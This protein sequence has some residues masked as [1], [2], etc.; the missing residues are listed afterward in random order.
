MPK[1]PLPGAFAPKR[2]MLMKSPPVAYSV[3]LRPPPL[4]SSLSLS[5]CALATAAAKAGSI[6]FSIVPMIAPPGLSG[7]FAPCGPAAAAMLAGPGVG[8]G[9]A[10]GDVTG[11]LMPRPPP[12]YDAGATAAS[13][14]G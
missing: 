10:A 12:V 8:A 6:V 13:L 7:T 3:K 1:G 11:A 5:A 14:S 2:P 4:T 9:G